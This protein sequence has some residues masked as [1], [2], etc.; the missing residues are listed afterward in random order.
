MTPAIGSPAPDF[1]L[2]DTEGKAFALGTTRGRKTLVVFIPFPFTGVCDGEACALR[3]HLADLSAL[4]A[5]V[6]V[7]TCY[8]R[9]ANKKWA[10]DNGFSFPV[11]SDFWP[12]GDVSRRYGTFNEEK[13][14]ANRTSFVLDD[15]GVLRRV[16]ASENLGTPRE[17]QAY[18][19]ALSS[20]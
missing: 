3:D 4:D 8:P 7:I 17:Y 5:N 9:Q 1:S 11:L 2:P 12:H 14:A 6:V 19:E 20:F 10:A 15:E 16:V 18:V 13:G